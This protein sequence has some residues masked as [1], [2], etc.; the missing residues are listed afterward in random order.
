MNPEC[1]FQ[2]H[3]VERYEPL[4]CS[5]QIDGIPF[6]IDTSIQVV[7]VASTLT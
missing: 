5:S 7:E 3:T 6:P 4:L 1:V 2:S